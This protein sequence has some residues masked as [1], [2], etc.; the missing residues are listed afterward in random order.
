MV[1]DDSQVSDNQDS[2][3]SA[4]TET[5]IKVALNDVGPIGKQ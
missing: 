5:L 4:Q 3:P 1:L 2:P